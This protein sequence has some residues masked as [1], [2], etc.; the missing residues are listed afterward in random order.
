MA[1]MNPGERIADIL[2]KASDSLGT[3]ILAYAVALAAVGAIVMAMLELLKALLRLRYWFHRF[4]TDRWVGADAQ[5]RVEFIALTTGGYA[6]EGAL[7]D[8]PIE[9]LMAQVQAGA[10]MAMDFPD[11]YP[12][13]YAFLTSQPDLGHAEDA[14]LWMNHASG[15]RKSVNAGEKLAASD[16]DREAGKARARLQNLAA[17]KVDG[18]QTETE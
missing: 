7:F 10:N 11:R 5:R 12:K 18:F 8:Q 14:T 16:E 13:F 2:V 1:D 15:Q 17:R 3:S 9:K 6:S 4:Q